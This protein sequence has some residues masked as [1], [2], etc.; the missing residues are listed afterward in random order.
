MA[1]STDLKRLRSASLCKA[2][3]RIS[4][5]KIYF[6]SSL[7][8]LSLF[9]WFYFPYKASIPRFTGGRDDFRPL[10]DAPFAKT[11]DLPIDHF[12]QSD[13]RTFTN[14]YWMND[15]YYRR[16]GPVFFFDGGEAGLNDRGAAQM[17]GGDVVFAP[18]ELARKYHGVAIIWEHRFFGGSMPF[19]SNQTTGIA[20]AGYN[21]YKFLNNE[22]A[23]E[24]AA[25][26]AQHF[27]PIGHE[28]DDMSS[29]S[30]PWIAIGGSYAG[31][32]AAMLRSRNP[33]IFFAS[34]PSSA[35]VQTQVENSEYYN[36]IVETIS[37]N[38][39]T[40][41]HAAITYADEILFRGTEDE[42][43][44]LKR[45]LFLTNNASVGS[46]CDY[47]ETWNPNNAPEFSFKSPLSIL[48][49]NSFDAKPTTDGVK[50]KHGPKSAF[51]AFISATIQ[52]SKTL[53]G[54]PSRQ[55]GSISDRVSWTWMLCNQFGQFPVSQ[56]PSPTSIISRYNNI[57]SFLENFCHGTFPYTPD[58]PK[59][60]EILR[61][62]GWNMRPSNV[63]FTNG[64]IDPWRALS[65]QSSKNIHPNAPDRKTTQVVPACNSP[66]PRNEVFGL[67]HKDSVHVGDLRKRRE[68][69]PGPVD[70]GFELFSRALD[71]W[72]P[73][74]HR[75]K[76]RET[77]SNEP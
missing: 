26:F 49:D 41:M 20:N 10:S 12:N 69:P 25:Y 52:V 35:P 3:G 19:P 58:Q 59:V 8:L 67:V 39:S 30:T 50:A 64:E 36:T 15:T 22:Q 73:C 32:R 9:V 5:N 6:T 54:S 57:T 72:L 17:L 13:T 21:A 16:G 46:F 53:P 18:L 68:D 23:L 37:K 70:K 43:A 7:L 55:I 33:E 42:I 74:F 51:Y 62:R 77:S 66:P 75:E 61:Y 65:I 48:A 31:I 24:D 60:L 47:L 38:C 1:A 29:N 63:M 4:R 34:W 71:V 28:K 76:A 27:R 44:L 14:R 40:D 11:I 45:A 56:Y 2:D